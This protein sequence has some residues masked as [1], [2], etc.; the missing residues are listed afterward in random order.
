MDK[1]IRKLM[2]MHK[3]LHPRND[4]DRLYELRKEG[5]RGVTSIEDSVDASI[6]HLE[7]YIKKF[8]RLVTATRNNTN[9]TNINRTKINCKQIWKEKQLYGH[10]KWKKNKI[11]HG[12]TWTWLRKGNLKRDTES[13]LIAVQ[14]NAIKTVS[15]Q[16]ETKCNKIADVYYV[17][18]NMKGSI[19][20][21]V[22][23]VN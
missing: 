7:D 5:G 6:Q 15:K 18:T 14:N 8:R 13:L 21:K 10:I 22:K 9:N 16:E 17:V 4:V 11:S 1:W 12:K 20:L 23:A 19:T 3:A 2:T